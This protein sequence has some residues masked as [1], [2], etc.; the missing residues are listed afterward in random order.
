MGVCI[1]TGSLEIHSIF[2]TETSKNHSLAVA[3]CLVV[4][5][6]LYTVLVS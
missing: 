2:A 3:F 6:L 1:V 4:D 5:E